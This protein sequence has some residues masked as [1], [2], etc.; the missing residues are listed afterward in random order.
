MLYA[1]VNPIIEYISLVLTPF[2]V[3]AEID[4]FVAFFIILIKLNSSS[5]IQANLPFV[6]LNANSFLPDFAI[7]EAA[8]YVSPPVT[9]ISFFIFSSFLKV[10]NNLALLTS[11]F[12]GDL[13]VGLVWAKQTLPLPSLKVLLIF[14]LSFYLFLINKSNLYIFIFFSIVLILWRWIWNVFV[15][16]VYFF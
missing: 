1:F 11:N 12:C 7:T 5:C 2:V 9:L 3:V 14:F 8:L 4:S 15:Y 16:Q 6:R 13:S 10:T